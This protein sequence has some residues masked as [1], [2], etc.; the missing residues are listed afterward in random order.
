M[1][2]ASA[3]YDLCRSN[4]YSPKAGQV[5]LYRCRNRTKRPTNNNQSCDGKLRFFI[6]DVNGTLKVDSENLAAFYP[7]GKHCQ[8]FS[9]N[10]QLKQLVKPTHKL[11]KVKGR[12]WSVKPKHGEEGDDD[13]HSNANH[14]N[15]D[16]SNSVST[17]V[18]HRF[19]EN[20]A[21]D[22]EPEDE[23]SDTSSYS[24]SE[25]DDSDEDY[26]LS[27]AE[28]SVDSDD[29]RKSDDNQSDDFVYE[30]D[31]ELNDAK[32]AGRVVRKG[33]SE[34]NAHANRTKDEPLQ[35][36]NAAV[37]NPGS[38]STAS[39]ADWPERLPLIVAKP[40]EDIYND[41]TV[42][43]CSEEAHERLVERLEAVDDCLEE[44]DALD[45]SS[46]D[47]VR[48]LESMKRSYER[49]EEFSGDSQEAE[50]R[51]RKLSRLAHTF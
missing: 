26:S 25:P 50:S 34:A 12:R 10:D 19:L 7:H 24:P 48:H 3:I 17:A 16:Q 27:E 43:I 11:A 22:R 18:G 37:D 41:P 35:E 9:T 51:S 8:Y 28:S 40:T 23:L 39:D 42:E 14:S 31:D 29:G 15:T 36:E 49:E 20:D 38:S 13:H 1:I 30:T 47:L 46:N 4:S 33:K 45:N 21:Y 5:V 44:L 2:Y 32:N 6:I